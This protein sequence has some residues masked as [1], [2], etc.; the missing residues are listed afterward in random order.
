[1][2]HGQQRP[3]GSRHE[4]VEH[5][6]EPPDGRVRLADPGATDEHRQGTEVCAVEEGEEQLGAEGGDEDVRNGEHTQP[7]RERD[8]TDD[9]DVEQV[10]DDHDPLA[11]QPVGQRSGQQAD[12]E[13][14]QRLER[15]R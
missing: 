2:Q 11:V 1:V 8:R 4:Q 10:R 9:E 6:P 7:P 3:R 13:V 15:C 5:A 12:H 14:G